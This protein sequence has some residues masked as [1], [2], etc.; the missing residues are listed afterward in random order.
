VKIK[1]KGKL[2]ETVSVQM[3]DLLPSIKDAISE[4]M[5]LDDS[6]ELHL[7][8]NTPFLLFNVIRTPEQKIKCSCNKCMIEAHEARF[9]KKLIEEPI[10]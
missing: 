2:R 8:S 5:E 10:K 6:V 7:T 3:S 4:E 9:N 1:I